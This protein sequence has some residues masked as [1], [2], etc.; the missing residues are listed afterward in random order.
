[1][2]MTSGFFN[3][4]G[5]DRTYDAEDL[6]SLLEG[7]FSDGV[8]KGIGGEL[9]VLSDSGMT[10][11]VLTGK[12][13]VNAK[14]AKVTSDEAVTLE[15]ADGV[16]PRIDLV[17][18]RMNFEN[19][20]AEIS[21]IKGT[22]AQDPVAPGIKNDAIA[23]DI[24]LAQIYVAAQTT[25]ITELNITDLREYVSADGLKNNFKRYI[26]DK[27]Y[28]A[29]G[30]V[31]PSSFNTIKGGIAV[32]HAQISECN[33]VTISCDFA[34]K[35][36]VTSSYLNILLPLPY[37]IKRPSG[38]GVISIEGGSSVDIQALINRTSDNVP[39]LRLSGA[40]T[41]NS[42]VKG[43]SISYMYSDNVEEVGY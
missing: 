24:V 25:E 41:E 23:K 7:F 18:L 12:G 8:V 42:Y 36:M 30:A 13:I 3:S 16:S 26:R 9:E 10:V 33:F 5:G 2:A 27:A 14:W 4:V 17:V 39:V 32:D 6:S 40:G 38:A 15:E 11:K 22:A 35:Q 19:R 21:V 1:M 20:N 28:T 34:D 29:A 43:I 31:L 37:G